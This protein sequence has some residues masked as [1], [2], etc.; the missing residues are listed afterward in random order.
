[1][2]LLKAILKARPR[3]PSFRPLVRNSP[4]INDTKP[5]QKDASEKTDPSSP[6]L[7]ASR[8]KIEP[9]ASINYSKS[10]KAS[11][12]EGFIHAVFLLPS[13]LLLRSPF[14]F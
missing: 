14:G 2:R 6:L 5:S 4:G 8:F 9:A 7:L 3:K 11:K 10:P 13:G 12:R 1:M